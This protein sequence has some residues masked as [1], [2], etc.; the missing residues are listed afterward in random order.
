MAPTA[1]FAARVPGG[2]DETLLIYRSLT[3]PVT[4]SFLGHQTRARLL[5]GL[6]SSEGEVETLLKVD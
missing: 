6:F 4:R 5:V 2:R 3:P 1:P